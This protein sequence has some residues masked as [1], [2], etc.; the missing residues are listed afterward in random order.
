MHLLTGRESST[1][2]AVMGVFWTLQ[3]S[4]PGLSFYSKLPLAFG[5]AYFALS[6]GVNILLTILIMLR[7]YMYRRRITKALGLRFV[8][9]A[10]TLF[11]ADII[12][13]SSQGVDHAKQYVSLATIIIESAGKMQLAHIPK[14]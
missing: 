13:L 5:T 12:Q 14:H 11:K 6:F 8:Y 4:Q 3:S 9:Y 1:C 10:S 2:G 7:L